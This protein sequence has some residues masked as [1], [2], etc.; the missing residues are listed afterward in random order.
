MR[1]L[2]DSNHELLIRT[3]L[4]A[5]FGVWYEKRVPFVCPFLLWATSYSLLRERRLS[6]LESI[7]RG[8]GAHDPMSTLL[9]CCYWKV[10]AYSNPKCIIL[11]FPP[12]KT[13]S[14]L[15]SKLRKHLAKKAISRVIWLRKYMIMMMLTAVARCLKCMLS[16]QSWNKKG[17]GWCYYIFWYCPIS[18]ELI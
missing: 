4:Q 5:S 7:S 3:S 1:S 17:S 16:W 13:D 9:R 2:R 8:S 12:T 6:I 14:S 11:E 15:I 18:N 10:Y